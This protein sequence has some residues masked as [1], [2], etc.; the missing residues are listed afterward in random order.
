MLTRATTVF[1]ALFMLG[2]LGLGDLRPARPRSVVSGVGTG[3]D[4]QP[5]TP[6][7]SPGIRLIRP[8]A[9]AA[10]RPDRDSRM[11]HREAAPGDDAARFG[12]KDAGD[13]AA[14]FAKRD[15]RCARTRVRFAR[16][17]EVA[18]LADAPA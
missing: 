13:S 17:A 11:P 6:A 9:E 5:K 1:G 16:I 4:Q 15:G 12:D 8:D 10:D 14:R 3:A 2:A 18:E 7:L